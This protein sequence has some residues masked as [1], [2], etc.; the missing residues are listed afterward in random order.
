MTRSDN[1]LIEKSKISTCTQRYLRMS[2]ST[3]ETFMVE[4]ANKEV[5]GRSRASTYFS[6]G[7]AKCHLDFNVFNQ[8]LIVRFTRLQVLHPVG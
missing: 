3:Q 2:Y 5:E 7:V 6:T 4:S 1:D 8:L